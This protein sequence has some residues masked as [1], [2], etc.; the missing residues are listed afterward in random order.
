[1][2][3]TYAQCTLWAMSVECTP[4]CSAAHIH[5][6]THT[7]LIQMVNQQ[8]RAMNERGNFRYRPRRANISHAN[9]QRSNAKP[10]REHSVYFSLASRT[11]TNGTRGE[12][13]A[14]K[15]MKQIPNVCLHRIGELKVDIIE[16]IS[17][18]TSYLYLTA[19]TAIVYFE[20]SYK[21]EG[22]TRHKLPPMWVIQATH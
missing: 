12:Q 14:P 7:H 4:F 18:I 1:M 21:V 11:Y 5:T 6:H 19:T 16:P 15:S 13:V 9:R 20:W 8:W 2:L 22:A 10:C 17:S 3:E